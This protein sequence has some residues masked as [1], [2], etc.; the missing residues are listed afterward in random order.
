MGDVWVVVLEMLFEFLDIVLM[1]VIKMG[2]CFF[3]VEMR[4]VKIGFKFFGSVYD[5]YFG[6]YYVI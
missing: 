4:L 6:I 5:G 2:I 1:D 3:C